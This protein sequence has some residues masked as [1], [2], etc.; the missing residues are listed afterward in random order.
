MATYYTPGAEAQRKSLQY[1]FSAEAYRNESF[2]SHG[3]LTLTGASVATDIHCIEF[4]KAPAFIDW[5]SASI[6]STNAALAGTIGIMTAAGVYTA[7]ATLTAA[8]NIG[9]ATAPTNITFE[10]IAADCWIAY[11]LGTSPPTSG[12]ARVRV[13]RTV[14]SC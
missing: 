6:I 5:A 1:A 14:L 4:I 13:K 2:E 11:Q 12:T 3:V 7:Y 10:P 9:R 8:T